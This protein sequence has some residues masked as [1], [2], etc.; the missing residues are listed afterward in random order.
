MSIIDNLSAY[1]H[2]PIKP[3]M[4]GPYVKY[5]IEMS[6]FKINMKGDGYYLIPKMETFKNFIVD[7]SNKVPNLTQIINPAQLEYPRD[8]TVIR[9]TFN[10]RNNNTIYI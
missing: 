6:N 8:T 3:E 2:T 10:T 4:D 9:F 1:C 5:V 7:Q